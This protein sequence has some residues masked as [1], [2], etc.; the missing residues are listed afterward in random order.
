[1][2]DARAGA[3]SAK[4]SGG[5]LRYTEYAWDLHLPNLLIE[6]ESKPDSAACVAAPALME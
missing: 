2:E 6:S 1:M 4:E 5:G 3:K